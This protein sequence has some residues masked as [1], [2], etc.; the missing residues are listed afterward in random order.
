[1]RLRK[2]PCGTRVD[3]YKIVLR[4][5]LV[6]DSWDWDVRL[7]PRLDRLPLGSGSCWTKW[8]ARHAAKAAIRRHKAKRR[9]ALVEPEIVC[10]TVDR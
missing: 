8:G 1:M 2:I 9:N 4:E 3:G 7:D 5:N 6:T 10:Y